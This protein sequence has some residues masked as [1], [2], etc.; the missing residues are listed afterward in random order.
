MKKIKLDVTIIGG[1]TAGMTALRSALKHTEKV[2]MIEGSHF[3]TTCA[4]VGC[5]PSKLLIAAAEAAHHVKES[6]HFGIHVKEPP[7]INGR[8]V[9]QRVQTERD[10]FVGF[11]L[12]T[13]NQYESDKIIRGF[14]RFKDSNTLIVDEQLEIQSKAI[15]IATGSTPVIPAIFKDYTDKILTNENIFELEDLPKSVAV[16]GTGIIALELGQALKRLG[17]H[18]VVLARSG[19]IGTLTDPVVQEYAA[20]IMAEALDITIKTEISNISAAI[21]A[22]TIEFK[23]E[24]TEPRLEQFDKVLLAAGRIPN[25]KKLDLENSGLELDHKGIP[26]YDPYTTQCGQ[27]HIFLAGDV[28]DHHPILHEAADE[29]YLAGDNAARFPKIKS[30]KRRSALTVMFS[31]PQIAMVGCKYSELE[32]KQTVIGE[33][34]FESQG[35]SRVMLLNKGL[36]RIYAEKGSG[37]FLGAEMMGPRAEHIGHL[38]SWAHQQKLTVPSM[39]DM[40]FYHPVIEE[41][42]RTALRDANSKLQRV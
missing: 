8:E 18:V 9:M 12:D 22:I 38:L 4:R 36:L 1:G 41:G 14:A 20:K 42:L 28:S 21:D 5:M 34:S 39:L 33:V 6:K 15:V 7:Q 3:G 30:G 24:N 16:V 25:I 35:R 19:R 40:P 10:R 13:I 29:G 32:T 26:V 27:S 17:V 37:I 23:G 31:D 2:A 11:V